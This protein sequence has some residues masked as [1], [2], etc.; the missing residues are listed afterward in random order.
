M[1]GFASISGPAWRDLAES[2]RSASEAGD[3]EA[4][5]PLSTEAVSKRI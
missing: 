4:V 1:A 2:C 5:I 3:Q